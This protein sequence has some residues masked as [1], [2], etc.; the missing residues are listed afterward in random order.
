MDSNWSFLLDSEWLISPGSNI[1]TCSFILPLLWSDLLSRVNFVI[2][3]LSQQL[4]HLLIDSIWKEPDL[5]I[6]GI[7]PLCYSWIGYLQANG[8]PLV[9]LSILVDHDYSCQ[10]RGNANDSNLKSYQC[11][12]QILSIVYLFLFSWQKSAVYCLFLLVCPLHHR[13]MAVKSLPP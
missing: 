6:P 12:F 2:T 10:H 11:S 5:T 4:S 1:Y 3:N 9:L 8:P 13:Q 7:W